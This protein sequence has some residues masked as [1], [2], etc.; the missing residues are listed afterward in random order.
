MEYLLSFLFE[1]I[2]YIFA[3]GASDITD[4][5]GNTSGGI[6]GIAVFT[7]FRRFFREKYISI[8][9]SIGLVVEILAVLLLGILFVAD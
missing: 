8:I 9:N 5:I 4:I 7:L 6:I 1:I 3:I 2:Q